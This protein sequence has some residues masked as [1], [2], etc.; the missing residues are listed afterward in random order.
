ME[1]F[2][3]SL[4]AARDALDGKELSSRELVESL[5][6]RMDAA[7]G[8]VGAVVHRFDEAALKEADRLDA[9]RARGEISGPLHGLPLTI[10][11]S[12]GTE[13][14]PVTLGVVSRQQRAPASDAV[15][16]RLLRK[17]G[18][19]IVGKTNVGQLLLSHE[20]ENEIWG[21]TKNPF[22]LD[23][24]PG[25][26]SGGE[27]AAIAS[28]MSLAGVGTDIGGSIRVPCA[29]TGT[30]GLKPT[31]DRWSNAGS[32]GAL[33]GQE[34]VRGQAGPMARTS[35]DLALL[36][37]ALEPAAQA[38]FDPAVPP[39]EHVGPEAVKLEGLR[40]GVY[41]DDGFFSPAASVA[42]V[43][44]EAARH[45]EAA[46][47]TVV[48]F[49]PP[50]VEEALDTWFGALSSDGGATVEAQL[51]GDPVV[52]QLAELKRSAGLPGPV[53]KAAALYM[54]LRGEARVKRLLEALGR[55]PVEVYWQLAMTR[56][57]LRQKTLAA[58]RTAG[59]DAVICPPHATPALRHRDASDF[60]LAG[61]YSMLYNFMNFPAG[62]VPVGTVALAE[63][64]RPTARD[65]LERKARRVEEGSAGLPLGVQVVAKPYAEHVVLRL[66]A[67]IEARARAE[68]GFPRPV[69]G[70][71]S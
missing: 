45:L 22:A 36:M 44:R 41:E 8:A 32:E 57:T 15:V 28:G 34:V 13:G 51:A 27:A 21:Q 42:R 64:T 12:I 61:C 59:L 20:S 17:A 67:E 39:L 50:H 54:G 5:L 9:A 10:K 4:T 58:W 40:V 43:V 71:C 48:P 2:E 16:V 63:T 47:C 6:R 38:V 37:A 1:P 18:A 62:V 33:M 49:S 26:S 14:T 52:P 19:I 55:K 35:S 65:R 31:V 56:T 24:V 53:R 68:S 70:R 3:R 23:R 69:F 7:N 29:W 46:G 60:A 66:M 11:E 25:G 30:A